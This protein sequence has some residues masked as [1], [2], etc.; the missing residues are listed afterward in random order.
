[1]SVSSCWDANGLIVCNGG[2]SK[3]NHKGQKSDFQEI[4]IRKKKQIP[5]NLEDFVCQ[6]NNRRL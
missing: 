3:R 2:S 6:M 5:V 1:M 4:V